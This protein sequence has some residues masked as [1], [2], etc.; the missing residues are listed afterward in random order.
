[1]KIAEAEFVLLSVAITVWGPAVTA[2]TVNR[3]SLKL[4]V[5]SA[6]QV[7]VLGGVVPSKVKVM[8]LPATKPVP[9]TATVL[10]TAPAVPVFGVRVMARLTVKVAVAEYGV[11]SDTVTVWEPAVAAGTVNAQLLVVGRLPLAFVVQVPD[12]L[13]RV[14]SNL[15]VTLLLGR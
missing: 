15:T 5:A 12:V 14:P 10:L 6:V 4:P 13:G 1:M 11:P 2:E 3:Q 7:G 8:G 9:L